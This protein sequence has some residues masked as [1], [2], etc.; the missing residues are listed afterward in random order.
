MRALCL[1]V[2]AALAVVLTAGPASAADPELGTVEGTVTFNGKPVPD[3]TITFHLP[4]GQF[5]G[6]KLK[7]GKY[8]VDRVPAGTMRVTV[9]SKKVRLPAKYSAEDTSGLTVDVKAGKGRADFNL[10]P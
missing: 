9:E 8:R 10:A 3:G 7:D 4:D 1:T 2:L 6:A 5:V